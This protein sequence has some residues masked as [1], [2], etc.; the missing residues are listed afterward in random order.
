MAGR[1][2]TLGT[3]Q[4]Q[5]GKPFMAFSPLCILYLLETQNYKY[6]Y[7]YRLYFNRRPVSK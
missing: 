1:H 7:I 3:P 6:L 4:R 5:P 2:F